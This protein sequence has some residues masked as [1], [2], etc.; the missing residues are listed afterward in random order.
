MN[1]NIDELKRTVR[2][3]LNLMMAETWDA[4]TDPARVERWTN[5]IVTE[6]LA[7]LAAP[8]EAERNEHL[9]NVEHVAATIQAELA[10]RYVANYATGLRMLQD[11]LGVAIKL[12]VA[13][14]T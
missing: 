12:L 11:V 7:A 2:E 5:N 13:S 14:L 3:S 10:R 9:Q 6:R 1:P 8:T 4:D